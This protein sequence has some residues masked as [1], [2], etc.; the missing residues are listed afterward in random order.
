MEG[1]N[2]TR[3]NVERSVVRER[4]IKVFPEFNTAPMGA[5][6]AHVP[7]AYDA[8]LETPFTPHSWRNPPARRP[9]TNKSRD[10]RMN[11]RA[12]GRILI[13]I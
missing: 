11:P 8:L 13:R 6:I 2:D 7:Q 12:C 1:N 4:E 3:F 9:P 5:H 10:V